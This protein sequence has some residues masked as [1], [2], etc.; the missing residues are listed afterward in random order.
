[1]SFT[2][3]Q[4]L[5]I[6]HYLQCW[7]GAEAAR[8]AGYSENSIHSIAS[9]NLTKPKIQEE[10][11]KRI[12]DIAM[13]ADEVL[14]ALSEIARGNIEDFMNV[15][16]DGKLKFDFA[17]AKE[18]GKLHLISKII[19]T[20]E[21]LKVELHDRMQALQLIGRHFGMFK[22]V[23]EIDQDGEVTIRI[24]EEKASADS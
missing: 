9:E 21:G 16:E 12:S 10:I 13:T 23:Q 14:V 4:R 11:Q 18:E 6:E 20:R 2:D 8:K 22:D 19:P 7:N 15:D 5:F 17:R 24:I 1:M 3:K